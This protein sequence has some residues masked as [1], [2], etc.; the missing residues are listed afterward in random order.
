MALIGNRSHARQALDLDGWAARESTEWTSIGSGSIRSAFLH[1]ATGVI[2]KTEHSAYGDQYDNAFEVRRFQRLAK[3]F[4]DLNV[5]MFC[6]LP[7]TS[8]FN[9]DGRIV[10]AMEYVK[11]I[12]ASYINPDHDHYVGVSY[13]LWEL[14]SLCFE[15][16]H[17]GNYLVDEQGYV[18]PIDLGSPHNAEASVWK[19]EHFSKCG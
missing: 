2:Y 17:Y 7:K 6:R 18:V 11:G 5:G 16:M 14:E 12:K 3:K 4:P 15:D 19:G 9:I 10:V 8:G 13:G 1:I